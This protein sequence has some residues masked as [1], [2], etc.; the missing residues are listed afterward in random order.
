MWETLLSGVVV[1]QPSHM[2]SQLPRFL[3]FVSYLRNFNEHS[4]TLVL[5][6]LIYVYMYVCIYSSPSAIP[7]FQSI[8]FSCPKALVSKDDPQNSN[9][10]NTENVLC[11]ELQGKER[12]KNKQNLCLCPAELDTHHLQSDRQSL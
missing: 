8:C 11:G 10:A 4:Y 9:S 7:Y 3:W 12:Y 6:H 2:L 5:V 1:E